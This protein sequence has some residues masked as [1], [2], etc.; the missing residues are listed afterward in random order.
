MKRAAIAALLFVLPLAAAAEKPAQEH[1][2]NGVSIERVQDRAAERRLFGALHRN[3][4]KWAHELHAKL[5]HSAP[6]RCKA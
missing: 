2:G 1:R 3:L 6:G 5:K 4:G